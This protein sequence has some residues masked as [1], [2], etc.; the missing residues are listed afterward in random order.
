MKRFSIIVSFVF[1]VVVFT[2]V[3][4]E[5]D[6]KK[7]KTIPLKEIWAYQMPGTK[8]V[9]EL[10]PKLDVH[11]PKFKEAWE[12]S[13]VRQI[14]SF[15]S[16]GAPREG[17][18]PR[19]AFVVVGTGKEALKKAHATLKDKNNVD[20]QQQMPKDTELSLV[21]FHY[22]TGWHPR[23]TSVEQSR[24]S[25]VVKYKFVE[26]EEPSFGAARFAL[27]P[28]RKLSPGTVN[29][30]FDQEQP[31]DYRGLR[32]NKKTNVERLVCD[33]FSFEVR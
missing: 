10:E 25:I 31:V 14:V 1:G 16:S 12:R 24:D 3:R 22:V 32:L 11:D 6:N 18:K 19:P 28:L 17:E 2:Q 20:W 29:V 33:S 9:R 13:F 30:K 5:D 7:A 8:D 23:V 26:P 27:I 4:A 21:F 15:L